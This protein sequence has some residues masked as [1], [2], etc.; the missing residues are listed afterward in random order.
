MKKLL[1][2]LL[3]VPIVSFGQTKRELEL[4]LALQSRGFSS[5]NEA[6]DALERVLSVTGLRKNFILTP[7][8]GIQNALAL[9]V[10]GERYIF[11][12]KEFLKS[13]PSRGGF[14]NL[15][16]LAHE[17]GHHLNNHSLD[18]AL[19]YS[20][21]VKPETKSVRRQ[22]ELEADEFAGFV[23]AKLGASLEE[24]QKP[25]YLI[26]SNND[27]SYSTHPNRVKRLNAVKKGYLSANKD[28]QVSSSENKNSK[29]RGNFTRIFGD[30]KRVQTDDVF[31]G[32]KWMSET[33]GSI[34]GKVRYFKT[35][36]KF[37]IS[38]KK[39]HLRINFVD[40][41]TQVKFPYDAIGLEFLILD[42]DSQVIFQER[43]LHNSLLPNN[44]MLFK[45]LKEG[46]KLYVRINDGRLAGSEEEYKEFYFEY[47]LKGSSSALQL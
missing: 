19:Y 9:T 44:H 17:V 2:L 38:K 46:N 28:I 26:S 42:L 36:P 41:L 13:I 29:L 24:A 15:A 4:C 27:D 10:E 12:D 23:M 40:F 37:V 7:C 43:F 20:G 22:Q 14:S 1:L 6:D 35:A 39:N 3:I 25:F 16:I 47:S 33:N 45:Y 5:I 32:S 30:W 18:F 11:Y 34:Q 31:D 21:V 8:D